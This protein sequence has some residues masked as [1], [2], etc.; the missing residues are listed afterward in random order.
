[1]LVGKLVHCPNC[2]KWFIGRRASNDDLLIAEEA[3]W[4]QAHRATRVSEIKN[5]EEIR[6]GLDDSKYQDM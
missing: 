5:E 2:G 3:A 1:L 4:R 6:K